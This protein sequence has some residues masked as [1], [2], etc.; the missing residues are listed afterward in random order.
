MSSLFPCS[1]GICCCLPLSLRLLLLLIDWWIRVMLERNKSNEFRS[2]WAIW[3]PMV[4]YNAFLMW[5]NSSGWVAVGLICL[6]KLCI[7]RTNW[8]HGSPNLCLL[9]YHL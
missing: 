1:G 9:A 3:I 8:K 7:S 4:G 6:P 5:S 2:A